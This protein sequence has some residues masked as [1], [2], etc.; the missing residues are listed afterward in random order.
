M[1]IASST[2]KAGPFAGDDNST[3]FAFAFKV[4]TGSDVY[5]VKLNVST[6]VETVLT[7]TTDYTVTLNANQNTNPGGTI[8]LTSALATGYTLTITSALG[9]LQPTDLTNQGG[10]YASVITDALDRAEIQIQQL[11]EQL[12]RSIKYPISDASAGVTLPTASQR[13]STVLAFD[14]TGEPVPGLAVASVGTVLANIANI[15]TVAAN[16]ANVSVAAANVADITNFSDVY[17]GPKSAD[18]TIRNDSSALQLGDIYFNTVTDHMRVYRSTGWI[19]TVAGAAYVYAA[20][21]D[22]VENTFMLPASPTDENVTQVYISGVYQSKATYSVSGADVIFSAP[23]PAGTNNIEIVTLNVLPLGATDSALAV[24]IPAGAGAVATTVQAELRKEFR[25]SNYPTFLAAETAAAGNTLIV[26]SDITIDSDISVDIPI[27]IIHPHKITIATGKT[28]TIKGPLMAGRYQV[29]LLTGTGVVSGLKEAFP[30]WVGARCDGSTDDYTAINSLI[31]NN[32][33]VI[34]YFLPNSTTMVSCP[35]PFRDNGGFVCKGGFATIKAHPTSVRG[36]IGEEFPAAAYSKIYMENIIVDGNQANVS[37]NTFGTGGVANDLYQ[38]A[39][40]LYGVSNSVFKHVRV[41]NSVMNGWSLYGANTDNIFIDPWA[42]SCG[43]TTSP[44]SGS[45]Y[46]YRGIYEEV[47]G[48]RNHFIRP[49]ILS[50]K[51]SAIWLNSDT[52]NDNDNW[53][54]D[55]FVDGGGTATDHGVNIVALGTATIQG[56]VF[57]GKVVNFT[58]SGKYGVQATSPSGTGVIN[59]ARIEVTVNGCANGIRLG[60]AAVRTML[61]NPNVIGMTGNGVV[62]DGTTSIDTQILGGIATGSGGSNFIDNGTRTNPIG[63]LTVS[64]GTAQYGKA[65][66]SSQMS[67]KRVSTTYG[68][69]IAIDA[70]LGNEF[71]ITVTD[72]TAFT[73]A[74]PTSPLDGQRITI[75]LRNTSGGAMGTVTWDTLYKLS[76]WISPATSYSRSIDFKYN[77]AAWIETSRTTADIPL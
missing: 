39:V 24:Y 35:L 25:T 2:R 76:A 68:T 58:A 59:D 48:S 11:G 69:S 7:I 62:I 50:P 66:L 44:V 34:V 10:F 71:D 45:S 73:I 47:G 31:I 63:F 6:G 15:N 32:P 26:D 51:E 57:T 49:Y 70:S 42:I 60:D 23:P 37:Y 12:D 1:T 30:E 17:Q 13:A 36:V 8:T 33:G 67:L 19:E 53:F 55:A 46:S 65:Q 75:T 4:F 5:A 38:N 40:R 16:I 61:V 20:S 27:C 74:N 28:L 52:G 56:P 22:G 21:G 18:P 72:G 14:A 9:Y 77:G 43:K 41:Y 64:N 54:L 3:V 29:I